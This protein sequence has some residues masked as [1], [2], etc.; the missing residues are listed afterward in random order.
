MAQPRKSYTFTTINAPSGQSTYGNAIND[1]GEVAGNYY[2]S[3]GRLHAFAY[4]HGVF[5]ALNAPPPA[6]SAEAINNRGEVIAHPTPAMW[7]AGEWAASTK[8]RTSSAEAR[9]AFAVL[10]TERKA[11]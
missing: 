2:D 7:S 4:E 1:R 11:A 6:T 8:R 9:L 3:S 5:T 10:T